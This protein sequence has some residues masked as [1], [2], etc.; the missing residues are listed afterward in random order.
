[1]YYLVVLQ[2]SNAFAAEAN[3]GDL[4]FREH[5]DENRAGFKGR[6][7]LVAMQSCLMFFVWHVWPRLMLFWYILVA[8]RGHRDSAK[9]TVW[10]A[11][12]GMGQTYTGT[13]DLLKEQSC[14]LLDYAMIWSWICLVLGLHL[15]LELLSNFCLY[16]PHVCWCDLVHIEH[17]LVEL[18]SLLTREI[19]RCLPKNSETLE[20]SKNQDQV[21]AISDPLKVQN[22]FGLDCCSWHLHVTMFMYSI[23]FGS[24]LSLSCMS[25]GVRILVSAHTGCHGENH[26]ICWTD[27][28][29]AKFQLLSNTFR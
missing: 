14:Y 13:A 9:P 6:L 22:V 11:P 18:H 5:A 21:V 28:K 27:F 10:F 4:A 23:Y 29:L 16:S 24:H 12:G 2:V 3:T 1:M 17:D 8:L 19:G 20:T 7:E 15:M 25:F 26:L